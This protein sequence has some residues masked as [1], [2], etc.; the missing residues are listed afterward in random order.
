M[1]EKVLSIS[2]AD[3]VPASELVKAQT[4]IGLPSRLRENGGVIRARFSD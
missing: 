4:A 2:V 1:N 3:V